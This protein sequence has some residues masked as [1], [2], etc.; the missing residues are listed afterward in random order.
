MQILGSIAVLIVSITLHEYAHGWAAYKLGDPTPKDSGRLTFNPL[1]HIDPFG[2]VI[3]PLMLLMIPGLFP[4]GY[5]KPV[6]INPYHFKN[7]RRDIMKVGF[8]GPAANFALVLFFWFIVKTVPVWFIVHIAVS[9]MVINL[10]LGMFNLIPI[11]PLDGSRVASAFM[12]HRVA[13][14]YLRLETAG[15]FL[16]LFLFATGAFRGFVNF[17][18]SAV[19]FLIG[20]KL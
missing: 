6:P 5:A 8:A 11:P 3:L 2:T 19:L 7:P 10:L 13:Y 16:I 14:N 1:S 15:V 17:I 4:I 12:S 20:W 18:Y 9:G